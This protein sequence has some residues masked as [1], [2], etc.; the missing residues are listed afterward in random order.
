MGG[1]R[2]EHL[3]TFYAVLDELEDVCG[4]ARRLTDCSGRMGWPQRGAVTI[5]LAHVSVSLSYVAVVIEARLIDQGGELEEAA[6]DLGAS[7]WQAFLRVTLPLLAPAL[8]A[9]WLL[10]FTLSL[11][12]LVVASFVS[13]PGASTLPMVV[14]SALKLGLTPELNALATVILVLVA[15]AAALAEDD[16]P[17][18]EAPDEAPLVAAA[19]LPL[20]LDET[21]MPKPVVEPEE[22]DAPVTLAL[23]PVVDLEDERFR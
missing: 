19:A 22:L 3:K 11:D 14:F 12:D 9:G 18:P 13:G 1:G 17:L 10:A 15:L 4:G 5:M 7:P 6:M 23:A 8:M 20:P 2:L 16:V 21:V